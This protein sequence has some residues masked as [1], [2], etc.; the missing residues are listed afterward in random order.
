L[1]FRQGRDVRIAA[2]IT[3]AAA[4]FCHLTASCWCERS[5]LDCTRRPLHSRP[6]SFRRTIFR[7]VQAIGVAGMSFD[8]TVMKASLPP[9]ANLGLPRQFVWVAGSRRGRAKTCRRRRS[10][11]TRFQLS[12]SPNL[13]ERKRT[14]GQ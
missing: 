7:G 5:G 14:E 3:G 12:L 8:I 13:R 6:D 11:P 10:Q 9:A 4:V 1:L 2:F